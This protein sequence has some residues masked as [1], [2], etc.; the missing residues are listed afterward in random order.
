MIDKI[1]I[2]MLSMIIIT[3]ALIASADAKVEEKPYTI[4]TAVSSPVYVKP[5]VYRTIQEYEKYEASEASMAMVDNIIE[6]ESNGK[7]VYGDNGMAYGVA[8]FWQS[9]L[10][11]MKDLSGMYWLDYYSEDSQRTLLLWALDNNYGSHWTCY[12]QLYGKL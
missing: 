6:C 8:Q 1:K 3:M 5:I 11:M 4:L 12:K 9:T 7:M 10:N 2:M